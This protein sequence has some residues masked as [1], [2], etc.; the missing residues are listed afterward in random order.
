[1]SN[2]TSPGYCW[3]PVDEQTK[4][5]PSD[6]HPFWDSL[7]RTEGW[8]PCGFLA[9]QQRAAAVEQQ[10]FSPLRMINIWDVHFAVDVS[11]IWFTLMKSISQPTST[12]SLPRASYGQGCLQLESCWCLLAQAVHRLLSRCVAGFG[13]HWCRYGH[14]VCCCFRLFDSFVYKLLK[15]IKF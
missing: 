5:P 3:L 15:I 12:S 6:E 14:A 9:P 4:G 8:P 1:M 11:A 7:C 13:L 10:G 2:W